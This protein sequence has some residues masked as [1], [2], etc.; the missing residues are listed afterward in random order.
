MTQDA[1]LLASYWTIAG[2]ALPH[3][4]RE[5]SPFD[6]KDRVQAA[7]RAGFRGLG[8]WHADLE[9]ILER[10]SLTEMKKILDD[11]GITHVELEF[12]TDWFLEGERKKQS[13]VQKRKLLKAAE[14]LGARHVKVGDFHHEK[15]SM[16]QLIEAFAALCADAAGH[17]TRIGFELMPFAMIDT[18]KDCLT[19]I[20]GAGAANGGIVFDLWH[21]V[22]LHIPYE[23]VQKVPL[24]WIVGVELNDGTFEAPWSLHE[25]TINHRRFCGQGEFDVKGFVG[26]I[27]RTGYTGPWGI[28]VLSQDLRGKPLQELTTEAFQTTMEHLR[29]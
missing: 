26:C 9:H 14:T 27:R 12:L 23:Q 17:G 18:L 3:T 24:K 22:K 13:D 11:N 21:L 7:A 19:M 8:I 1:D 16:P 28:E 5:Y 4:D 2:G 29:P 6:F 25:E 20:E 10:R 15:Y